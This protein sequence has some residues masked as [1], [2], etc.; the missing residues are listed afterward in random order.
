M[1]VV[2]PSISATKKG[3]ANVGGAEQT[4]IWE[5]I[6]NSRWHALGERVVADENVNLSEYWGFRSHS[7]KLGRC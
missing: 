4:S 6:K 7:Q 1:L 5:S 3:I 2:G